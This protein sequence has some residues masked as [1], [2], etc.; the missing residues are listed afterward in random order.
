[1][2]LLGNQDNRVKRLTAHDIIGHYLKR[3]ELVD[4]EERI[5]RI[6]DHNVYGD[7]GTREL[8]EAE[9]REL[10]QDKVVPNEDAI[11]T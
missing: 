6:K 8:S 11:A 4:L 7:V 2:G 3:R 5:Q 1:M 9:L 10:V